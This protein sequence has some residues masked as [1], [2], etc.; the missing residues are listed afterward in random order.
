MATTAGVRETGAHAD[1]SAPM[2]HQQIMQ[3]LYGLILGMFVAMLSSTI[4]S[5]ALPKIIT[6]LHGNQSAYTWVVTATLLATTAST[7]LWGKLA[8]LTSKKL[9]VQT[10]LVIFVAG[11]VVAGLSVAT[12]ILPVCRRGLC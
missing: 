4:V 11:S 7:P 8:D 2:S 6:G 10:A 1:H 5:T 3:A 12:G 9:L